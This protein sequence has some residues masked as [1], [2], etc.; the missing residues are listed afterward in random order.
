MQARRIW[1][2]FFIFGRRRCDTVA[3]SLYDLGDTL[4]S[5]ALLTFYFPLWLASQDLAGTGPLGQSDIML[6]F[7]ISGSMAAVIIAAPIMGSL[8]DRLHRRVPLLA[9]CVILAAIPVVAIGRFD[10]VTAGIILFMVANFVYQLSVVFHNSLIVNVTTMSERGIVSGIGVGFGFAALA[11]LFIALNPVVERYGDVAAFVPIAIAFVAM[12]VPL[13]IIVKERR[14]RHPLNKDLF[15]ES[16]LIL[17]E[18]FH[19]ARRHANLFRFIIARFLY[20][21]A[22][23]TFALFLIIY[24]L[25]IGDVP[26]SD[27]RAM[28][29][30]S[31][32]TGA[33]AAWAGGW[34]ES[35][36]GPKNLLVASTIGWIFVMFLAAFANAIWMYWIVV[37]GSGVL[38]ATTQISDRVV[39][40]E[41]TPSGQIGEFFGLFQI[42]GRRAAFIGPIVWGISAWALRD[43]TFITADRIALGFIVVLLFAALFLLLR[44]R[45]IRE[46]PDLIHMETHG[47][48]VM[49]SSE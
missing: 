18:T 48:H 36:F 31:V 19:R 38:W 49:L 41:L 21:E 7:A 47:G 30:G 35:R 45:E 5:G 34:I 24:L 27:A 13:F 11:V 10:G 25:E 43:S 17:Y 22:I 9:V 42:S 6:A 26:E 8:S 29:I 20:T 2:T 4:F 39:L 40:T 28:V 1:R 3:W 46:R 12:A 32:I 16:Y 33:I 44:V 37:M 23:S 15:I 14:A